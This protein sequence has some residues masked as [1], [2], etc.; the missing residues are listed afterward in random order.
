MALVSF[1]RGSKPADLSSLDAN[2]IYFFT[3]TNEIYLGQQPYGGDLTQLKTDLEGLKTKVTTAEGDIDALKKWK[4]QHEGEYAALTATDADFEE[5]IAALEDAFDNAGDGA[6]EDLEALIEAVKT[7]QD[8]YVKGVTAADKSVTVTSGQNPTVKVNV[9]TEKDNVLELKSD[10]LYVNVEG[11]PETA[12]T[13]YT[14]TV[15]TKSTAN[16]G[17]AKTY[18][19][20][21]GASGEETVV[22]TIDIPKDLV[23]SSGTVEVNADDEHS[24]TWIKLVLNNDDVIWIAASSLVDTVSANNAEGAPVTIT[25]TDGTKI[26]ATLGAGSVTETY[27]ATETVAKITHGEEAYTA[28]SWGTLD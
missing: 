15:S 3:D 25:V 8:T 26:G 9:S 28:L 18:E 16:E 6:Y 12:L 17:M 14:V 27:I 24:G 19:I 13:D 20:K 4:T 23:V 7:I 22:G 2:T 10:G 11:L 1:K 21:Q 5:R